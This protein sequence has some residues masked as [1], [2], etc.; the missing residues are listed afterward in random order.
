MKN[1]L[2]IKL[3]FYRLYCVKTPQDNRLAV[4]ISY[5]KLFNIKV[6]N[7]KKIHIKQWQQEANKH[8]YFFF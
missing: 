4:N 8:A 7:K 5:E 3:V 2:C 6:F 1:T